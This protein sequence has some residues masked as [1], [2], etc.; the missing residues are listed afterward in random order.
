MACVVLG[1]WVFGGAG[2]GV[3]DVGFMVPS[4]A[5]AR[6]AREGKEHLAH[7]R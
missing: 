1:I 5:S 4:L 6:A 3:K 2:L 7:S